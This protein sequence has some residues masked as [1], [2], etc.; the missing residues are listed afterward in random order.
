VSLDSETVTIM[1]EHRTRQ[2]A[3]RLRAGSVWTDT[4]RVFARDDGGLLSPDTPTQLMPKPV[5]RA[6]VT[7]AP[8]HDLRH[9]H[10]TMLLLAGVPVHLV[11]ARLGHADAAITL[12]VYAHV[13]RLDAAEVG[14][15]FARAVGLC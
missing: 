14:E 10:A 13:L 8:L 1:R 9:V 15:T 3:E 4:D 7:A 6:G 12:R 11:A 5:A 2:L